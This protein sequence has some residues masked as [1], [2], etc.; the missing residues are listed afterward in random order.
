MEKFMTPT[1]GSPDGSADGRCDC[2]GAR[3]RRIDGG[4]WDMLDPHEG[5]HSWKLARERAD[6]SGGDLK[7]T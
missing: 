2:C 5:E 3:G 4:E 6:E 7:A 1:V